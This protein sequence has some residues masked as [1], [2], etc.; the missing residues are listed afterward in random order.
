MQDKH[1]DIDK[2]FQDAFQDH[3]V[4]PSFNMWN[5]IE[6]NLPL[7]ETD[8]MFKK[9]FDGYEHEPSPEVWERIKPELPLSLTLRNGFVYLSRIAAVLLIGITIYVFIQQFDWK[10][11][12]AGEIAQ[13][14]KEVTEQNQQNVVDSNIQFE[15]QEVAFEQNLADESL[16]LL[17]V[18]K[19][20]N[21]SSL[22]PAQYIEI[23][24]KSPLKNPENTAKGIRLGSEKALRKI[25]VI[26]IDEIANNIKEGNSGYIPSSKLFNYAFEEE[27]SSRIDTIAEKKELKELKNIRM[28]DVYAFHPDV[29]LEGEIR[30]PN[31]GN[32]AEMTTTAAL[33][34]LSLQGEADAGFQAPSVRLNRS[35]LEKAAFDFTGFQFNINAGFGTSSILNPLLK[36]GVADGESQYNLLSLGDNLGLGIG[37]Q[38]KPNWL[39]ETGVNYVN[40]SQTYTSFDDTDEKLNF[41]YLSIPLTFKYRSNE[42]SGTKPS[43]ISYVFGVQAGFLNE[44]KVVAD[45]KDIIINHELAA[46]IGV[47]Y[48]LFL[49][50][51]V[52][53]TI[54]A[55]ATVG[56]GIENT[57]E[58]YNTFVGIRSAFNFRV[59]KK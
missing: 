27:E 44:P 56:T 32:E 25:A 53:W 59:G 24:E 1:H 29:D 18:E 37:Y 3:E 38:F 50:P 58:N 8:M 31:P 43:A 17:E 13:Q 49:N 15:E 7:T 54:G 22:S 48:D 33:P 28:E 20:E 6:S 10:I 5:K 34:Y 4:V 40:Q 46:T 36:E 30:H 21:H 26:N 11:R 35:H 2:L 14:E 52:S 55:R 45:I 12:N 39:V 23:P 16:A 42:I 51:N 47:D 9:A 41:N 19:P 57:F